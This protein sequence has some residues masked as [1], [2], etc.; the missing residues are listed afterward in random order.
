[1]DRYVTTR[2]ARSNSLAGL[3]FNHRTFVAMGILALL[4]RTPSGRN[5]KTGEIHQEAQA[6]L[7]GSTFLISFIP[8]AVVWNQTLMLP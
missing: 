8:F 5:M 4:D 2:A 1:M 3:T 6:N 7:P